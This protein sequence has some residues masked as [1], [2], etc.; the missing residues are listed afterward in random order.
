MRGEAKIVRCGAETVS[1]VKMYYRAF[2]VG[3]VPGAF[4]VLNY[5]KSLKTAN[6]C[7]GDNETWIG[8]FNQDQN[9][10]EGIPISAGS[11]DSVVDT[12]GTYTIEIYYEMTTGSGNVL[13]NNGGTNYKANFTILDQTTWNG[14]VWDNGEPGSE[15]NA[16]VNGDITLSSVFATNNLTITPGHT[17]TVASN[18]SLKSYGNVVNNGT[19][20]VQ[21]DATFL[22]ELGDT[23]SGS[24]NAIVYRNANLKRMDYNYWSS[25]VSGQNLYNFSPGTH[26]NRFY[27]YNEPTDTFV[28][29][30]L[31]AASTFT[32]GVGYA[33]RGKNSYATGTPTSETFLFNGV[34]NSGLITV[35]LKKSVGADKGYNLVGNPYPSNITFSSLYNYGN[36]RNAIFNRQWFWTNLNDVT[37]QQGS[38]YAGNNYA[39]YVQGS[40]GVGPTYLSTS[41]EVPS[42]RPL[43]Y[44]KV[45]QG[46]IV[47]AKYDNAPLQFNN[48]IR[49]SNTANSIFFNKNTNE[50]E[51][52]PE[53]EPE[54]LNR[55]WLKL[56]SPQNIGNTILVAYNDFATNDYDEDYDAALL[57]VGNDSFY[58]SVGAH[59]MQIQSRANPFSITDVVDLGIKC[60]VGGNYIIA[61]DGTDGVFGATSSQ[62]IYLKDNNT[63]VVTNLQEGYYTFS[64]SVGEDNT[65]FK[66]IYENSVLGTTDSAKDDLLIYKN[67]SDLVIQNANAIDKVEI[68]DASGKLVYANQFKSKSVR[69]NTSAYSKGFYIVKV[70]QQSGIK[71]KKIIL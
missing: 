51:G 33:I 41:I 15:V 7:G 4:S 42:L 31:S 29:T 23:Y 36:N 14:A 30:G 18:Y 71:T 49:S 62:A 47:Q 34:P 68:Y 38:S 5:E 48:N 22:Q 12:A 8:K 44:T 1:A 3:S 40:G 57:S 60:S 46:F 27:I 17:L 54:T 61:I 37:T 20:V 13:L 45:A 50:D 64:A 58:S 63:N 21:N 6:G 66:I 53:D 39:T 32:P 16:T 43:A 10:S 19:I 65:R 67:N 24:G 28:A 56:I 52:E 55:Y 59:K 9:N 69:L 26:T 25:P 11:P 35:N 2:K 70:V